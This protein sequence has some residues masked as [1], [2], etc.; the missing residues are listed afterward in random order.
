MKPVTIAFLVWA[1]V[2]TFGVFGIL[3]HYGLKLIL[4][5]MALP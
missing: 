1:G 2:V 4:F 3:A 5:S